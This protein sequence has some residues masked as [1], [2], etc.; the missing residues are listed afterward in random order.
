MS[1]TRV[2]IVLASLATAFTAAWKYSEP[3]P[4]DPVVVSAYTKWALS[5]QGQDERA[6]EAAKAAALAV[7][8]LKVAHTLAVKAD[9]A[10]CPVTPSADSTD[11]ANDVVQE[12]KYL[13]VKE[14]TDPV[15]KFKR[16]SFGHLLP[17]DEERLKQLGTTPAE[18]FS[19]MQQAARDS[20]QSL[21]ARYPHAKLQALDQAEDLHAAT[22]GKPLQTLRDIHAMRWS[23]KYL[24]IKDTGEPDV[25]QSVI[26]GGM[27]GE[28][29]QR[30]LTKLA[31]QSFPDIVQKLKEMPK[32][33]SFGTD[34]FEEYWL[35]NDILRYVGEGQ[36]SAD[37][38]K[39]MPEYSELGFKNR[40]EWVSL[41]RQS[42]AEYDRRA[43]SIAKS[44]LA[45]C[46]MGD[47]R[48]QPPKIS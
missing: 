47:T 16:Y 28:L 18:Y 21:L 33:K 17:K 3:E 19:G 4:R 20:F 39:E 30:V 38:G 41:M 32:L 11:D 29:L 7:P 48:P 12:I 9:P 10:V 13:Q 15:L 27:D 37:L 40:R 24:Q 35:Y 6:L 25:D 42:E 22:A 14:T 2:G 46:A 5:N 26:M 36:A 23:Q 31:M 1:Y 8:P 43:N 45:G 34:N 44:S